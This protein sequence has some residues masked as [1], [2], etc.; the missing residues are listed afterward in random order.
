M[1][2]QDLSVAGRGDKAAEPPDTAYGLPCKPLG[3]RAKGDC[4]DRC[5]N[6]SVLSCLLDTGL[7][8]EPQIQSR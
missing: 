2:Y 8:F 4:L 6:R 7:M 3:K 5:R 1:K